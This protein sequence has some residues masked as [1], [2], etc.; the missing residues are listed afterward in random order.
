MNQ[1]SNNLET[2]EPNVKQFLKRMNLKSN[3]FELMNQ[4]SNNFDTHEPNVKQL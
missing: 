4:M 1:K 2:H 3:N